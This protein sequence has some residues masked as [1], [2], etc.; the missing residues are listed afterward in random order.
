MLGYGPT[1]TLRIRAFIREKW[2]HIAVCI[3]VGTILAMQVLLPGFIGLADNGDFGKVAGWLRIA[4]T[5]GWAGNYFAYFDPDYTWSGRNPAGT[6]F[7]SSEIPLA[8]IAQ[9]LANATHEGAHFDLRV[10]GAV[11]AVLIL[12]AFLALLAALRHVSL[13][14]R[15]TVAAAAIFLFTDVVYIAY[16]NSLYMDVPAIC[17]L[18]LLIASSACICIAQRPSFRMLVLYAFAALLFVTSKTQHAVW[19]P[20]IAMVPVATAARVREPA[21]RWASAAAA[22]LVLAGLAFMVANTP[23]A[24][25]AAALFNVLF[26]RLGS[27]GVHAMPDLRQIGAD[28]SDA[29]YLG[30]H[31]FL[32]NA[33][34]QDPRW[35]VAFYDRTG[36]WR[37]FRW[38]LAHPLR[39]ALL[40]DDTLIS[41]APEMRQKTLSNFRREEGQPK[42]ARTNRFAM[43]SNF[44]SALFSRWPHHILLW[45]AFF[46]G[47]AIAV[48]RSASTPAV[49]RL[50]WLA[51]GIAGLAVGE[52][53]EASLA[54]AV[55]THRHLI[56]FHECT[57]LTFCFVLA[58]AASWAAR[59]RR[60]PM[61]SLQEPSLAG[62][63]NY[64][65]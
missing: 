11:G 22:A 47:G 58:W 23:K 48:L 14:V 24:Y 51:L 3:V 39:T 56:V 2:L 10:L 20:L 37:L 62:V 16:L 46:I 19:A 26:F 25:R 7:L 57:D 21:V 59:R 30:M 15:I 61:T 33:P 50:A 35:A 38:Y 52:F 29:S 9:R 54:D 64:D 5:R 60:A 31:A 55:E 32:P 42:G 6:G 34:L 49:S 53:V 40:L 43:W 18:L 8:A 4:P 44:R 36:Y 17:G 13:S 41:R 45:Y 12:S 28:A 63:P 27:R 1:V 65:V